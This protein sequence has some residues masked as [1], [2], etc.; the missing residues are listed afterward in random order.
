[1]NKWISVKDR[2]PSDEYDWVLVSPV[3]LE[4][5]KLRL[6]PMMAEQRNGKWAS[7]ENDGGDLETWFS[8]T[9][10]HWMP[11]IPESPDED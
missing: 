2:L 10:T 8:V 1:M 7:L 5:P 3:A 11:V 4:N 6:V 9:V